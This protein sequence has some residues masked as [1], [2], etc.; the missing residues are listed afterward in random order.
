MHI[1]ISP[2]AFKHSLNAEEAAL[3]IQ[4]GLRRSKA[5]VTTECFPVADGGDGTGTLIIKKCKGTL[6]DAAVHDAL[7]RPINGVFGLIDNG[8]TAV[9]EMANASG[10]RL[11]KPEERNPLR[12]NSSGTGEMIRKALDQGVKKIIIGMGGS[13]TVDGGT[14]ILRALGVRFL[15]ADGNEL[16]ILPEDLGALATADLSA[17]DERILKCEVIVLCDVDNMLLGDQGSA[18]VFGPQKGASPDEVKKLDQAL[19]KLSAVALH[20]TGRDMAAIK[21]GGTAGGA[22]AGLYAFLNARLVNGIDHFL[23]L[24]DFNSAL[25]RADLVITGEGSIDEQTLQGKGPFG[26]AYHAKLKDLPVVAFAGNVPLERNVNLQAYFD[27]LMPIGNRPGDLATALAC[28]ADN[29]KR[30]AETL[31][32]MLVLMQQKRC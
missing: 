17:L 20:H 28:T 7:G 11:L 12:A 15:N 6:L 29:L 26:V 3:A 5:G 22:A 19:N 18:A 24:T 32:N 10:I 25:E 16:T 14:G 27:V 1:L 2:N 30:T 13:A 4:E 31:G 8:A 21:Y 9:I 23:S